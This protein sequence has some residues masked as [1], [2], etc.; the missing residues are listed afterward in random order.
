MQRYVHLT[1]LR[2]NDLSSNG[3]V[4]SARQ[5]GKVVFQRV[6][7]D[8]G[9]RGGGE[10]VH[11]ESVEDGV[12]DTPLSRGYRACSMVLAGR[13]TGDDDNNNKG[14][15]RDETSFVNLQRVLH[16]REPGF[17][18]RPPP[19]EDCPGHCLRCQENSHRGKLK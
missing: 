7:V 11:N 4:D 8:L 17:C 6:E 16:L 10:G 15:W 2:L 5:L 19:V 3:G 13:R 18:H 1:W 9:R 12:Y 14:R